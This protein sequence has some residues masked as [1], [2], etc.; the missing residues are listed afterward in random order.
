MTLASLNLQ[1][2]LD[3]RP[4]EAARIGLMAAFLFFLLAA[5]NVIKIVRDSLFLS[6]FPITE[7]PYVYLLAA[8]LASAV[9]GIY[10]RYTSMFSLSQVVLGSQIFMISNVIVFWVLITFYNFGSVLYGFYI[11]SA[12]VGLVAVAQFWTLANDMF[13]PREGKRLFGVLTAAGSLGG[14]CGGFWANVAVSFLFGTKQLLWL[15]VGLFA[16]AFGVAWYAVRERET[17][18]RAN[19][20]EDI[21]P[22]E[23]S[24][25]DTDG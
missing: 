4:G 9:I 5:N 20:R 23:N 14:M 1:R 16:G 8:L 24:T 6:R 3:V 2:F 25:R 10:S 21:P 11:W 12:I 13:N 22:R 7:L 19:Q 17:V 15:I 18:L